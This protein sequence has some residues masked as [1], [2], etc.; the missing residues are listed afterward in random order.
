MI[1]KLRADW[2]ARQGSKASLRD[3]HDQFLS[4]SGP[5]PLVRRL[6]LGEDAGSPL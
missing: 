6:M 2:M 3:F 1:L 5:V 4:Y